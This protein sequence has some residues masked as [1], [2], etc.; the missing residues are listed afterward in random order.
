MA[1]GG[2]MGFQGGWLLEMTKNRNF[3]NRHMHT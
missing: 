2:Y 1:S 3:K